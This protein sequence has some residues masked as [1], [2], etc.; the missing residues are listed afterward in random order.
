VEHLRNATLIGLAASACLALVGLVATA[1]SAAPHVRATVLH[2]QLTTHLSDT[3][4]ASS[5]AVLTSSDIMAAV[6]GLLAVL[7]LAFMVVTFIRRQP[8]DT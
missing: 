4:T 3:S 6:V 8:R 1:A 2:A 5:G 7:A